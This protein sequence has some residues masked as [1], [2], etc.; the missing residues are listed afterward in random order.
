M[1]IPPI[2]A[3]GTVLQGMVPAA[4]AATA[5]AWVTNLGEVSVSS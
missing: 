2:P 4:T 3:A 5:S 1:I